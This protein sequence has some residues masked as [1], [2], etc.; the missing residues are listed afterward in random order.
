[1]TELT[2]AT[3]FSEFWLYSCFSNRPETLAMD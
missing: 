2:T 3:V 1:M